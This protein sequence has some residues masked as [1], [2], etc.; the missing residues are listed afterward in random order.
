LGE[1]YGNDLHFGVLGG[2]I[3]FP[4]SQAPCLKTSL[5]YER[6]SSAVPASRQSHE[7]S[8][9]GV[10]G[11]GVVSAAEPH[12]SKSRDAVTSPEPGIAPK[13]DVDEGCFFLG[14]KFE[15][16]ALFKLTIQTI[17]AKDIDKVRQRSCSTFKGFIVLI[18]CP[19]FQ[20]LP[21]NFSPPFN[22]AEY[23]FYFK[24]FDQAD[25]RTSGFHDPSNPDFVA[26]TV[27][28][29]MASSFRRVLDFFGPARR[30][31]LTVHLCCRGV[32]GDDGSEASL[33]QAAIPLSFDDLAEDSLTSGRA[34]TSEDVAF[35]PIGSGQE[36]V[37][38]ETSRPR[39]GYVV[40]LTY[41]GERRI[42]DSEEGE[43]EMEKAVSA[44]VPP[45]AA[46]E[47]EWAKKLERSVM[48]LEEWKLKQKQQHQ[49]KVREWSC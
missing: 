24:I 15:A 11:G 41:Y 43:E 16:R 37:P 30:E 29:R 35:F 38:D 20:A 44:P 25:I 45:G 48:E 34:A 26:E 19:S 13:L 23:F 47:S 33:S 6:C 49:E 39:V 9:M 10:A 3:S 1:C 2:D 18:W 8:S 40:R 46:D 21:V 12:S 28:I 4:P 17:H 7:P 5:V 36:A 32:F 42:A 22:P 27:D 14:E 31:S